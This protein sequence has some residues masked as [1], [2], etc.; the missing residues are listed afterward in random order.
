[1]PAVRQMLRRA[2]VARVA[3][4]AA[5]FKLGRAGQIKILRYLLLEVIV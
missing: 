3:T 5:F 2:I 1:M 4:V